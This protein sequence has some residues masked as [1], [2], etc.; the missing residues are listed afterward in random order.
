MNGAGLAVGADATVAQ[1]HHDRH[2]VVDA[3]PLAAS[4]T[5]VG[6]GDLPTA[7]AADLNAALAA[8]GYEV[9]ACDPTTP[10][11]RRPIPR[12]MGRR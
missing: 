7:T 6:I 3:K 5:R 9:I 10:D 8:R 1:H 4:P 2:A 11:L 12:G